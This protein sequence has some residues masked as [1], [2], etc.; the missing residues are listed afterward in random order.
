VRKCEGSAPTPA[1]VSR[2]Q[3]PQHRTTLVPPDLQDKHYPGA[4]RPDHRQDYAY[5]HDEPQ[6][7]AARQ[8]VPTS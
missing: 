5:A 2:P 3:I 1:T 7:F 6:G 4:Q 8:Y